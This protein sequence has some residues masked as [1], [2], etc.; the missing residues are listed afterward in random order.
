[1]AQTTHE[2][3][4]LSGCYNT[5]PNRRLAEL[6]VGAMRAI[7]APSYSEEDLRWAAELSKSI[8]S[9]QKQDWLRRSK[10]PDFEDL[11]DVL[12]DTSI[13]DPWDEGERGGGSTDVADVSWNTPTIEFPTAT[14]ILGTPGHSWQFAAQSGTSIGHKS[15]IF[16]AK[17]IALSVIELMTRPD[18]L[19]SVRE[20]KF[21]GP[22]TGRGS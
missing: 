15:L 14:C 11:M 16:A 18:L 20:A 1:M 5:L 6:V 8:P 4:F 10:R 21:C 17:T 2:V 22:R 13:P 9:E 12:I 3:Q 19:D 7:G